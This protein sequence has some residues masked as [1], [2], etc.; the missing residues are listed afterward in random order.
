MEVY[1]IWTES[2]N[3]PPTSYNEKNVPFLIRISK[4]LFHVKISLPMSM[5]LH[6]L[7]VI[8]PE[9]AIYM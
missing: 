7:V 3:F 9:P 4:V 2:A 8:K 6:I 1:L 5:L